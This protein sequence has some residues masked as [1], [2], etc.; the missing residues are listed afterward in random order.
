MV[1][2]RLSRQVSELSLRKEQ[3]GSAKAA[4]P[5]KTEPSVEKSD[6]DAAADEEGIKSHVLAVKHLILCLQIVK[7]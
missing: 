6:G 4:G 5:S 3:Q 1:L 7:H 2:E